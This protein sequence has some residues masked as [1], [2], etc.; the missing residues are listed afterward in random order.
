[1]KKRLIFILLCSL[2]T[3]V[4]AQTEKSKYCPDSNQLKVDGP[5]FAFRV[6]GLNQDGKLFKSKSFGFCN[7]C[8]AEY[9]VKNLNHELTKYDETKKELACVYE[10][11]F[12]TH[13]RKERDQAVTVL[14]TGDY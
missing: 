7:Y 9:V 12:E 4:Y 6:E 13:G 8:D 11:Y 10:G 1:M 3:N 5:P 2:I 14:N